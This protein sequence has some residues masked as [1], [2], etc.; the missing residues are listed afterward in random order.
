MPWQLKEAD[1]APDGSVRVRLR[2]PDCADRPGCRTCTVDYVV[3]VGESL[4]AELI[5]TNNSSGE[6]IFENC[7]HTYLAV[8][9]IKSVVVAGLK[10]VDYLD[11][12]AAFVRKT[13]TGDVIRFQGEVDRIYL[14]TPHTA[15]IRD[16]SL[17]RATHIAKENSVSTV[18]WNPSIGKSKV[19]PDFDDEEYKQMVCVESGNVSLNSIRLAPGASSKL[20]IALSSKPL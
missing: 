2:L 12:L 4:S 1:P 16:L 7:L 17:R 11:H 6:F 15:I 8:G 19:I 3:T 18:V 14:D 9:D 10:G 5:I 20:K 13:E